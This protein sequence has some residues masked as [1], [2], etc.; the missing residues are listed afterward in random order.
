MEHNLLR[1]TTFISLFMGNKNSI[2]QDI[3]GHLPFSLLRQNKPMQNPTSRPTSRLYLLELLT[4]YSNLLSKPLHFTAFSIPQILAKPT[5]IFGGW[6]LI[7][8]FCKTSRILPEAIIGVLR[9]CPI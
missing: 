4:R 1:S 3:L 8:S 9:L 2:S 6:R 7:P 5:P